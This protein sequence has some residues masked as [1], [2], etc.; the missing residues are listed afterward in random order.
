MGNPHLHFIV[1]M[2]R[3]AELFCEENWCVYLFLVMDTYKVEKIRI[4]ADLF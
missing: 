1:R 2:K 3:V 4:I